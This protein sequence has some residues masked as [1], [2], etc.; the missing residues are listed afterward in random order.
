M[1]LDHKFSE[2]TSI[3]FQ[4]QINFG[5]GDYIQYS[6]FETER[7]ANGTSNITSKGFSNNSGNN[8]NWQ[9]SGFLLFRQRL[10]LP[11]RTLTVNTNFNL[12]DNKMDAL[13]WNSTEYYNQAGDISST[14]VVNQN[15][16]QDQQ[17]YSINTRATY[18][19]PL[20]NYFYLEAEY[21][22]NWSKS[23]S[24]KN[25]YDLLNGGILDP[26]YSN[27]ITNL[28]RRHEIGGNVLY[29]DDRMHLQAG[30]TAMP[31]YTY[32]G[33]T[34]YDSSTKTNKLQEYKDNRWNF[35]P[36]VMMMFDLNDNDN[37]RFFYRGNSSQPTTSTVN[38]GTATGRTSRPT[39]SG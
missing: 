24:E 4:P 35:S 3:L 9:T 38:S 14:R 28:N 34:V 8:N 32:N 25:T 30:F 2:N 5:G 15:A 21:S 36:T 10:G 7:I 33:T 23:I 37:L 13:N 39:I 17:S 20:G 22:Y 16:L 31:Q 18:T 11:G 1:R 29:Q 26:Q 19:E 12:S 27:Q 6:D